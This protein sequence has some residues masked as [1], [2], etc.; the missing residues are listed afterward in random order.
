MSGRFCA[1]EFSICSRVITLVEAPTIPTPFSRLA[2]TSISGSTTWPASCAQA[3]CPAATDKISA[4]PH[5][6]FRIPTAQRSFVCMRH[7]VRTHR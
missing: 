5:A 4:L 2:E 7:H 6:N 1:G 3:P